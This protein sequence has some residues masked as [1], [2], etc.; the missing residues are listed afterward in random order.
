MFIGVDLGTSGVK[1]IL[2]D[3]D[4][5]IHHS[6]T[7]SYPLII[8]A[9]G[10]T[11]QDP[12]VWLEETVEGLKEIVRGHEDHI[13]G[14][15]FSGQMHGL[16]LLGE[17]DQVL[18]NALLWN[19]QRTVKEV[20]YLNNQIGLETL[21]DETGNIA[22]TGLTAPKVL[23]VKNNEPEIFEKISK[24]MLPKDYLIYKL[25]GVFAS[26][27][28]DTSGTLYFDVKHRRYS[29]QMLA[30]LGLNETMCP[31]IFESDEVIGIIKEDIKKTL[32]ITQDIKVTCGGGDQSMGA[33]GVG[34]VED[35][36][37]SVSLGTS[38]VVFVA[39]DH[40]SIDTKSYLQSYCHANHH[41]MMMGVML[42]AAG[43]LKWW[44]EQIFENFDYQDY[45][46]KI[47]FA[48]PDE[49][50]YFL[51][52]LSGERSPINDPYAQG[53]LYGLKLHHRKEHLDRAVI[54]GI[55]F[56]L[57]QTFELIEKLG[58]KIETIKIT[59]GG[60]KSEKWAQLIATIFNKK[61]ERLQ[62]EEGPAFGAAITAMVGCETYPTVKDACQNIVKIKDHFLPEQSLVELYDQK[63]Q[64]FIKIYPTLKTLQNEI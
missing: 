46:K 38:G 34:V 15:G 24:V 13:Q 6:V 58:S 62:I 25:T 12:N 17:D 16:V 47:S 21:L 19:D 57:K 55:T 42:N 33:I 1:L 36:H 4:G 8:P 43:A 23:W 9:S 41:Y 28:T 18:R 32:S 11:E 45:F 26:D 31:K 30:I 7:K 37:C 49:D 29:E 22:L 56:A 5:N 54:E 63:Y 51:P 39:N 53:V 59:G 64:K 61:V 44:S 14:I 48:K 3:K 52:Y 10:W 40:F 50:L 27:T 35:G 60:A 20:E 2:V